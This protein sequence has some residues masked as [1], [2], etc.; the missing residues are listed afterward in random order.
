M[1]N[2]LDPAALWQKRTAQAD[3]LAAARGTTVI[4]GSGYRGLYACVQNN[5]DPAAL[6]QKLTAQ[7]DALA[8]ARGTPED[9]AR[10]AALKKRSDKLVGIL[11]RRN[12]RIEL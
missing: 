11:I 4:E 1:Q 12:A 8:A 3:A 6:R 2:N 7:A 9:A 5:L 10:R